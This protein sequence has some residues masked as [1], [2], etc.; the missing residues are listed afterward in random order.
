MNN[1]W[2]T[3]VTDLLVIFQGAL[4]S[5]IPWLEKAK[6][7]WEDEE[8]YDDWDNIAESLFKNIV[9]SSLTGEILAEYKIAKY[10]FKNDDYST[11]NL[12]EV[13]NNDNPEKKFVFIAFQSNSSPMDSIKVAVLDKADKVVG[14]DSLRFENLEFVFVKNRSGKKE[15]VENIKVNL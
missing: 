15:I 8:A 10:N 6:I 4:I 3:T 11:L 9:C 13:K 2:K 5:I 14:Y 7:K 12:I 1:N